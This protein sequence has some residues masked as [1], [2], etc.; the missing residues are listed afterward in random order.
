LYKTTSILAQKRPD[1]ELLRG[2]LFVKRGDVV[3]TILPFTDLSGPQWLSSFDVGKMIS[4]L[5]QKI[6][7]GAI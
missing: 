1:G 2:A 5:F 3:L 4:V 6:V 7:S